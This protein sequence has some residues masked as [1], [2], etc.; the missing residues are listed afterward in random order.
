MGG[1]GKLVEAMTTLATS[2]G[3]SV[4]TDVEVARVVIDD[5]DKATGVE[6]VSGEIVCADVVLINADMHHAETKLIP[7][8]HQTYNASYWE[9]RIISPST[10]LIY[11]GIRGRVKGLSHHNLI[12]AEHWNEHFKTIFENPSWPQNPSY[13]V[14]CPSKTDSSVAPEGDENIFILVPVAAGL[15]SDESERERMASSIIDHLEKT[16][17]ES[18]RSRIIHKRVYAHQEFMT[19][20]HAFMGTAF[21]PAHTFWQTALFRPHKKSAKVSNVYY[22][23]HYTQPGIGMPMVVISGELT[24]KQIQKDHPPSHYV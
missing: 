5:A 12:L 18:I 9:S 14:S 22:T 17:D 20:Y 19:D 15:T 1:M 16:L 4:R 21:G 10:F 23:G 13:Y 8:S 3:V 24:A 6:L 11:L 2:Y 7:L